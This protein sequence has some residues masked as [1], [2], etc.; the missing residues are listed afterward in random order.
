[1]KY[2]SPEVYKKVW[3]WEEWIEN[4]D[5]YCLKKLHL[6]KG[7]QCSYHYHKIKDETFY[8]LSGK[9]DMIIDKEYIVFPI[10][11]AIHIK[12]N[13]VHLFRG[14]EDSVILEVST[15]HFEND[16]YRLTKSK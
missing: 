16:S 12:P 7:H 15:Q 1:M 10:N 4:S 11:T 3:G 14:L 13:M 5:L 6:N 8:L 9:V 2:K